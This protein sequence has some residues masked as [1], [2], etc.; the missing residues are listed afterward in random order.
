MFLPRHNYLKY[1]HDGVV[2]YV[3]GD[4]NCNYAYFLGEIILSSIHY[5]T[6]LIALKGEPIIGIDKEDFSL[7]SSKG[8]DLLDSKILFTLKDNKNLLPKI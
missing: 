6:S 5:F 7:T 3:L 4:E 8:E 1:I 2:H